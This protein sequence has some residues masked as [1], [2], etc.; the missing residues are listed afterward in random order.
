MAM[1][2][3]MMR[4][5]EAKGVAGAFVFAWEDEWFKRTWNTMEHQDPERRQLWHDPLTNEQWFGLI[6]TDPD[7]VVDAAAELI[8]EKG[9]F[10]YVH[11]WADASWVH[12][13]ITLREGVPTRLGVAA[14]VVPGPDRTDYRVL[15]DTVERTAR[16]EVRRGLDPIRLDTP[17]RPYRPDEQAPWHVYWLIIRGALTMDGRAYPAEFQE[18]GQLLQ[19]TWDPSSRDYDSR[20]TWQVDEER[21]TVRLRVPWPMVG[22][23]D[24]SSRLA[25]GEGL[26]A[27]MVPV[28]GIDLT[29]EAEGHRERLW[30][31]WPRWN[32]TTWTVRPKAGV[33]LVE[34]AIRDLA[35]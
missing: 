2:A 9:P 28:E 6:A 18:V 12:L 13:D 20:S 35:P 30:F 11:V 15:V 29:F 1:V 31:T 25:L 33:E 5:L 26:P 22:M 21:R 10:E 19:G 17:E 32:H 34:D 7:P 4:M 8:P 23:A 16:L 27:E 14:D 3:D 24:P